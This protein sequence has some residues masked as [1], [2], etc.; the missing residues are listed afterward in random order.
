MNLPEFDPIIH[1][2]TRLRIMTLLHRN[3]QASFAWVR[4]AL[5]LTDGNLGRHARTLEAAGYLEQGRV[6][7]RNGFQFRFRITAKGDAAFGTY[8]SGLRAYL[9]AQAA[10]EEN[11]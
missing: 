1:Q 11:P 3:R 4:D 5:A 7:T 6:L 2:P 8:L 10:A 9:D